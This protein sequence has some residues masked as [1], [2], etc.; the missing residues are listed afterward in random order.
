MIP[1]IDKNIKEISK[2]TYQQ[3]LQARSDLIIGRIKTI[4]KK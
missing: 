3:F 4:I 1:P 2:K